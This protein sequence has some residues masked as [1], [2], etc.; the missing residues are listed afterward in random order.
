MVIIE[1]I[2]NMN[3]CSLVLKPLYKYYKKNDNNVLRADE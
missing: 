2:L 1:F 3:C